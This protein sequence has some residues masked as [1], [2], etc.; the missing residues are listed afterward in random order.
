MKKKPTTG[1]LTCKKQPASQKFPGILTL[2]F[3][4]SFTFLLFL[5]L[6]SSAQDLMIRDCLND[7]INNGAQPSVSCTNPIYTSDGIKVLQNPHPG[8]T[9]YPFTTAIGD[10]WDLVGDEDAEYRDPTVYSKP[11][12]IYVKVSNVGAAQSSGTEVLKVY[13]A[14]GSTGLT[15]SNMWNDYFAIYPGCSNLYLGDEV[16]KP[17]R[18]WISLSPGE[19]ASVVGA[20]MQLDL[21]PYTMDGVSWWDKQ[22]QIHEATHVHGG[23][24]FLGWHRELVNRLELLLNASVPNIKLPY[25]DWTT[26]PGTAGA[27]ILG[28]NDIFHFGMDQGPAG[29][30]FNTFDNGG[31]CDAFTRG[32]NTLPPGCA[33][34]T[35]TQV[36]DWTLP[37]RSIE[38][39]TAGGPAVGITDNGIVISGD[40]QVQTDQY[41]YFSSTLESYHG[42]AHGYFGFGSNIECAHGAFEDPMVYLM[43]TNVDKIFAKWQRHLVTAPPNE[44][45]YRLDPSNVYGNQTVFIDPEIKPW[46]GVASFGSPIP[47]WVTG[48]GSEILVK[49]YQDESLIS[50]PIYDDALLTIPILDPGQSVIMQVPWYPPYPD[51]YNC[52]TDQ[53]HFCLL[54][55]IV[56]PGAPNDGMTTPEI[57]DVGTN[58]YMNNNI[59]WKNIQLYDA[60]PGS[61]L[62]ACVLVR[63]MQK[64]R[65]TIKLSIGTEEKGDLSYFNHGQVILDIHNKIYDLWVAGGKAG[66]DFKDLGEGHV[67][68]LTEKAWLGNILLDKDEQH[69]V[70]LIF[71]TET[72]PATG[73]AF[74]I[75]LEQTDDKGFMGGEQ[76]QLKYTKH[77]RYE[78][79]SASSSKGEYTVSPNPMQSVFSITANNYSSENTA[80]IYDVLGQEVYNEKFTSKTSISVDKL[81]RGIYMLKI[82]NANNNHEFF[83]KIVKN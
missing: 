20:F 33:T 76:F 15:W 7:E 56:T 68:L 43:H 63:N 29:F 37:P 3:C 9:P 6:K 28:V 60:S 83:Q 19:R 52:F 27:D 25:W 65:S 38:R 59:A 72:V 67:E 80:F 32:D 69:E 77:D 10:A 21:T 5:S 41:L 12:Y 22:D 42:G 54:A 24:M 45:L 79:T 17:R 53:N 31:N 11:N 57:G 55:R 71:N 48:P 1:L 18:N 73:E 46:N 26:D 14:K 4:V 58:A 39:Y 35:C 66:K 8:Y 50:P 23:P 75:N 30:P 49:S 81:Q 40:A 16:T 36:L 62:I 74:H 70:C 47:P 82:V 44:H 2:L 61:Q 13:W 64:E 78:K 51:N 34:A